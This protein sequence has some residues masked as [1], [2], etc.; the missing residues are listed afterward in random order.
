MSHLIITF[1]VSNSLLAAA[2]TGAVLAITHFWR[3]PWGRHSLWLLVLIKLIAPPVVAYQLGFLMWNGLSVAQNDFQMHSS[4]NDMTKDDIVVERRSKSDEL[5]TI[6]T[7]EVA[8]L[9]SKTES[10]QSRLDP[11]I[12]FWLDRLVVSWLVLA[13]VWSLVAIWRI[14]RFH[15]YVR[16]LPLVPL[17]KQLILAQVGRGFGYYG[18]LELASTSA[19]ISP[20]LWP[21]G[22]PRIV[23]SESI[24]VSLTSEELRGLIAHE[25]AHLLRRDHW[26]RWFELAILVLYWWNPVMWWARHELRIAAEEACDARVLRAFPEMTGA[27][28]RALLKANEM[29]SCTTP[30]P[31]PAGAFLNSHSLK[32]RVESMLSSSTQSVLNLRGT[33]VIALLTLLFLPWGIVAGAPHQIAE[34]AQVVGSE[35]DASKDSMNP[36]VVENLLHQIIARAGAI[37]SGTFNYVI[38]SRIQG[39]PEWKGAVRY[40]FDETGWVRRQKRPQDSWEQFPDGTSW[41]M[42]RANRYWEMSNLP[43]N[44]S[45]SLTLKYSSKCRLA[46][47]EQAPTQ[48]GTLQFAKMSDYLLEQ[49]KSVVVTGEETVDGHLCSILEVPVSAE[50]SGRA[51]GTMNTMLLTGGSLRV[52]WAKDLGYALPIIECRDKF[53]TAQITYRARKFQLIEGEL[54]FPFE[55]EI[56]SATHTLRYLFTEVSHINQI[57]PES[58]F[59]LTIPA[60]T[61][62]ADA[63]PHTGD[64]GDGL[65]TLAGYPFRQFRTGAAYPRWFPEK[66]LQEMD[67]GLIEEPKRH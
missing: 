44:S 21:I 9:S 5:S 26:V 66:L 23:V 10:P 36:P 63:R 45:P 1:V 38:A 11:I 52:Y 20:L 18:P 61:N 41:K 48:S 49:I 47:N 8:D 42:D 54:Y 43:E 28:I 64:P 53:D 13:I 22:P 58:V 29:A 25:I 57:L 60:A 59:E 14:T 32:E 3:A 56:V 51:F 62:V 67:R 50:N 17:E 55:F 19:R 37:R 15:G 33:L 30:I 2:M 39:Q 24:L 31:C 7:R 65:V 34:P 46:A 27:Y 12:S 6:D 4:R 40:A 16:R 35:K